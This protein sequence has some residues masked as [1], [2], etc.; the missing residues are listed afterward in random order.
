MKGIKELLQKNG[1]YSI[2]FTGDSLTSCEWVHPNW[3][4]MVEYVL[5]EELQKEFEDWRIPS[6]GIRCFNFGFDG[7]TTRDILNLLPEKVDLV[8]GLMGGN[9][10]VL[11]IKVEETKSNLQ[12]IFERFKT[13]EIIW[14]TSLPDLRGNKRIVYEPYRQVTLEVGG[15]KV[16]DGFEWLSKFDL[17]KFFTFKSE[18]NLV[19]GI[20]EGEID[21]MHPNQLGNAYVAKMFLEKMGINFDPEK[22]MEETLK[23]EKLPKY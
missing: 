1:K 20:K 9:D 21:P 16:I 12:K 23:G 7:A 22:F 2:A 18:E 5:K 15:D 4:E 10:P 6:W 14:S 19:E 3:R 11:G 13:S 17:T 8:L